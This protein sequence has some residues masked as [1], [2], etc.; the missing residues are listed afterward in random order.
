LIQAWTSITD[1]M[2]INSKRIVILQNAPHNFGELSSINGLFRR[3]HPL[4]KEKPLWRDEVITV[5]TGF[6]QL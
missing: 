3:S 6:P 4:L 2:Q 5:A 1:D